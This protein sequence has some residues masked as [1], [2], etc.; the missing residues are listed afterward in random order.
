MNIKIQPVHFVSRVL[1]FG[2]ACTGCGVRFFFFFFFLFGLV[3][4][5][6]LLVLVLMLVGEMSWLWNCFVRKSHLFFRQCV[7]DRIGDKE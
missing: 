6:L 4:D 1:F 2:A 7:S 5:L 3:V